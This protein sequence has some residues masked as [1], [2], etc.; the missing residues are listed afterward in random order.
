MVH[1]SEYFSKE[2][3]GKSWDGEIHM[4]QT[5]VLL[6]DFLFN[7][8]KAISWRD[9]CLAME[10]LLGPEDGRYLEYAKVEKGCWGEGS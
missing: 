4:S 8:S 3:W 2:R 7:H 6:K 10:M 1:R 5:Q 9:F